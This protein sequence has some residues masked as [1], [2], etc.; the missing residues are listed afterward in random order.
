[1]ACLQVSDTTELFIWLWASCR[2]PHVSNLIKLRYT[3][4]RNVAELFH[5]HNRTKP[6]QT[7]PYRT[8]PNRTKAKHMVPYQ[9]E[10]NPAKPSQTKPNQAKPSQT[11]PNQTEPNQTTP[12]HTAPTR[13]VPYRTASKF[14][15][16]QEVRVG[17]HA[18]REGRSPRL[19]PPGHQPFPR[20]PLG[21]APPL[22]PFP[23]YG[24]VS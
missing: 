23:R 2:V 1:M 17:E 22:R 9:N 12:H 24:G 3:P 6:N 4:D 14:D 20:N 21:R 7:K 16:F 11:K 10:R 15:C 13:T 8:R 18:P 5:R 19:P